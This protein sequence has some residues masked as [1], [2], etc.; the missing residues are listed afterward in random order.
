MGDVR[1]HAANCGDRVLGIALS[2]DD[3]RELQIVELWGLPV[4]AWDEVPAGRYRLLCEATVVL[5]PD[6]DTVQELFDRWTYDLPRP[7]P[8]GA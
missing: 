7:M 2:P 8:A 1:S 6:V 3:H 5:I 4:L